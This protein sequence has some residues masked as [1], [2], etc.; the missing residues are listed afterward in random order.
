MAK[1]HH[2]FYANLWWVIVEAWLGCRGQIAIRQNQQPNVSTSSPKKRS[3][4]RFGSLTSKRMPLRIKLRATILSVSMFFLMLCGSCSRHFDL[5]V[6]NNTGMEL[7]IIC[8]QTVGRHP[9]V[10][11]YKLASGKSMIVKYYTEFRIKTTAIS[12]RYPTI[13]IGNSSVDN[14]RGK[15]RVA[16]IQIEASGA[17]FLMPSDS[18]QILSPLPVQPRGFPITPNKE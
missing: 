8:E 7:I 5:Q 6:F 18:E 3:H 12:W 9:D 2:H 14:R 16:K 4:N 17:L 1:N 10:K 13:V 11:S 15:P